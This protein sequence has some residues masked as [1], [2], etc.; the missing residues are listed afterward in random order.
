MGSS[1]QHP[2]VII[3]GGP[4][5]MALG[6]ELSR[7][8]LAFPILER[9]D[10]PGDSWRRMPRDM[11]MNS[12]IGVSCMPG[13]RLGFREWARVWSRQRFYEH[14]L[15]FAANQDF[16]LRCNTAVTRIDKLDGGRFRIDCG[17]TVFES[18]V[19]VNATGYFGRPFVPERQGADES[20]ILQITVPEYIEPET[21]SGRIRGNGRRVLIVGK[22][23]TA[24][25]IAVELHAAGFEVVI[26]HRTPMEFG[27]DPRT[28]RLAF[29]I[30]YP[31]E[32]LRL[33]TASFARR[34]SGHPMQGG[35]ARRLI[36]T[37][38]IQTRPDIAAFEADRIR[39]ADGSIEAFDALIW[40]TGYRPVLD[41]LS[42]LVSIDST[43]GLP[44]L[45]QMESAETSG[46]YFLGL[47]QETDFTSRMLRGICRDAEFLAARLA[48]ALSSQSAGQL[49]SSISK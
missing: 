29:R 7:R 49:K 24:G 26:S 9:A 27:F 35:P 2:L 25:Q 48:P 17:E 30:Y 6:Y 37:G 18:D 3:G 34:D 21:L 4:A 43:T 31:Y 28:Q 40:A 33:R 11:P 16:D 5:G 15:E 20:S 47:D 46:L 38:S 14:L 23:I 1:E 32:K 8:G 45:E 12:P 42:G 10:A 39:F 13:T 22:R 19:V 44:P 41:H 36:E